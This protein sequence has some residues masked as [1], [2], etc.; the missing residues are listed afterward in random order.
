M[1]C[2]KCGTSV[3]DSLSLCESCEQSKKDELEQQQVEN[4]SLPPAARDDEGYAGFWLRFWA[5]MIDGTLLNI[6][7]FAGVAVISLITGFQLFDIIKV[8]GGGV[9]VNPALVNVAIF[10][11]LIPFIAFQLTTGLIIWP[12]FC[13]VFESS[14]MRATPGKFLFGIHVTDNEKQIQSFGQAFLRNFYKLIS[15]V[16]I[17]IGFLMVAFTEK[18]QA[19][20]DSISDSLVLRT[21]GVGSAQRIGAFVFGLIFACAWNYSADLLHKTIANKRNV[22]VMQSPL[23][24]AEKAPFRSTKAIRTNQKLEG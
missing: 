22:A 14:E 7:M 19:L 24:P 9:Q 12:V 17:G 11:K 10:K 5:S 1:L 13:A 2:P 21:S 15:T 16:L 3:G 18:K 23:H 6:F 20:H 8:S 4:E